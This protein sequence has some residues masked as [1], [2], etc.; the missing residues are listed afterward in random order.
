VIVLRT[1]SKLYGMAGLRAGFAAGR[2]DLLAKMRP[3]QSGMLPVTGMAGAAASLKVKNLVPD[4]RQSYKELRE[5][6]FAFMD[7]HNYTYVKSDSNCFMI[8]VKRPP[9]EFQKAMMA[10]KIMVGRSWPVWPTHS[11]VTVGSK[12]DMEKFK[13]ALLVVMG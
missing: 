12:S 7:K 3:W 8:D 5:D 6:V 9:Q 13:A 2:P 11:R 4:R 10:Q 1:F